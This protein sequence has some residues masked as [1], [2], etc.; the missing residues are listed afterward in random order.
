MIIRRQLYQYTSVYVRRIVVYQT[1]VLKKSSGQIAVDLDLNL[2]T[3]QRIRRRWRV[4]GTIIREPHR[5]G[6]AKLLD[7]TAI[8]V[9]RFIS[10]ECIEL[11]P[12]LCQV[13][14]QSAGTFPRPLT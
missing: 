1:A 6:P 7:D 2:R 12:Q 11:T 14:C 8:N 13:P 5:E 3:V 10:V 4:L 9:G